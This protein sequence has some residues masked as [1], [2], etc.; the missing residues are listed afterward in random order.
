MRSSSKYVAIAIV[1][2]VGIYCMNMHI[3][4]IDCA[5]VFA[6][7]AVAFIILDRFVLSSDDNCSCEYSPDQGSLY[8]NFDSKTETQNSHGG[9]ASSQPGLAEVLKSDKLVP[10]ASATEAK[11]SSK[12]TEVAATGVPKVAVEAAPTPKMDSFGEITTGELGYSQVTV[13]NL[14]N[15]ADRI[16]LKPR[17]RYG[18]VFVDPEAWHPPCL[19]APICVTSNGCPVQP[20]FTNGTYI[21]L[22]EWDDSRRITPPSA[23]DSE[24][25]AKVLNANASK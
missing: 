16:E 22:L 20:V 2:A 6:A 19:R 15:A 24:Y 13:D 11:S 5:L 10:S 1:I 3:S 23:V 4:S 7:V 8:E 21:D 12:P 9:K 17:A 18:E 25:M 14:R